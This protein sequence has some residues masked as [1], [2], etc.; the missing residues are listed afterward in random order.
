MIYLNIDTEYS[1][2]FIPILDLNG[3]GD[4]YI[5]I[6]DCTTK[7]GITLQATGY[8]KQNDISFI[9]FDHNIIL[10][11][12]RFYDIEIRIGFYQTVYKD[13]IFF[14]DQDLDNFSINYLKYTLPSI[15]PNNDYI[16]L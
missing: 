1:I 6:T 11:K 13:R 3:L 14:T 16:V 9:V 4:I 10:V 8:Y 7:N 12:N 5:F 15:T 2:P